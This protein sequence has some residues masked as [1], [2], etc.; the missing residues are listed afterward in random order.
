MPAVAKET[1]QPQQRAVSEGP[2]LLE[3]PT[4]TW[5]LKV[6]II[7]IIRQIPTNPTVQYIPTFSR[8]LL[9]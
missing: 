5:R 9:S 3:E 2:T 4:A 8:R 1:K 6:E 7:P